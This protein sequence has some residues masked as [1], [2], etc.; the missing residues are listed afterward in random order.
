MT[1]LFTE[2]YGDFNTIEAIFRPKSSI[3]TF[4]RN[5]ES[6]INVVDIQIRQVLVIPV[7]EKDTF[8]FFRTNVYLRVVIIANNIFEKS[9]INHIF[10]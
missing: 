7:A 5:R 4:S 1:L 3:D 8:V 9:E 10:H 6:I 2:V